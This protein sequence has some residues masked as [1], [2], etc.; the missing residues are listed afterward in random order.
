[1]NKIKISKNNYDKFIFKGALALESYFDDRKDNLELFDKIN[2][3][4]T[5]Y[6]SLKEKSNDDKEVIVNDLLLA[7]NT[8]II[9]KKEMILI[10]NRGVIMKYII[11]RNINLFGKINII[12]FG[13]NVKINNNGNG[14]EN[15]DIGNE[16]IIISNLLKPLNQETINKLNEKN[17]IYISLS[18]YFFDNNKKLSAIEYENDMAISRI[19]RDDLH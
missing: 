19:T 1:M 15:F 16:E 12:K 11:K 8:I 10:S 2:R 17:P 7:L 14:F 3:K 9:K 6:R 13:Y 18:K 4:I 5:N